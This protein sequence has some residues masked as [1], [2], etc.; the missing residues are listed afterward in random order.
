MLLALYALSPNKD[1]HTSRGS[2][3]PPHCVV[4]QAEFLGCSKHAWGPQWSPASRS[5]EA[6]SALFSQSYSGERVERWDFK[7]MLEGA[8]ELTQ[9]VKALAAKQNNL[10]REPPR[11]KER[12]NQCLQVILRLPQACHKTSDPT[13]LPTHYTCTHKEIN[14]RVFFFMKYALKFVFMA[15]SL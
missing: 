9:Q 12:T 6:V 15:A 7:T 8:G 4:T 11:W 2:D 13:D 10:I 5:N 1:M 14:K 3:R